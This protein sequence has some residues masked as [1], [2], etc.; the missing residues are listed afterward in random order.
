MQCRL[1]G[2]DLSPWLEMPIDG[3]KDQPTPFKSFIRC[4]DCRTGMLT[5]QPKADQITELYQVPAYYTHGESHIREVP[6]NLLDKVLTKLSW[7]L[8][9]PISFDPKNIAEV[10]PKSGSVCDLGCGDGSTLKRFKELGFDDTGV[11]PDPCSRELAADSELNVLL[12]TA[13]MLPHE[14]GDRQFDLVIMRHSLEHCIDPGVALANAYRLTREG[15]YIYCEVPNCGCVHFET[16]TICSETFDSPRHL[17]FFTAAGLRRA[18]E[19]KGYIFQSW[20]FEGFTR[21]HL[22]SWR[23]WEITIFDRL[24][25][26]GQ[27]KRAKRHTFSKSLSI[28]AKSAFAPADR[29]YDCVGVV[30]R[31]LS[32]PSKIGLQDGPGHIQSV[33]PSHSV[34][35]G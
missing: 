33:S 11:E 18:I 32:N 17:W 30:A 15:G 3:K 8:D 21:H 1:C 19:S 16:L 26:R 28:L 12:G 13:E 25:K 27:A 23:A 7:K 6:S 10:L 29:K 14:L 9:R 2:G 4:D 34:S 35:I 20:R 22:P 31:K 5:P 24:A